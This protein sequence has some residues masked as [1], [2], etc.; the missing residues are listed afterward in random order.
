MLTDGH[1][2]GRT[3]DG[4]KVIT[5]AHPEHSSGEL[6]I[7]SFNMNTGQ[8]Y[9]D[10]DSLIE[11]VTN[12]IVSAGDMTL[13]RKTF[14]LKKNKQKKTQKLNKKCYDKD[15]DCLLRELKAAKNAFNRN[16]D[17]VYLRSIFFFFQKKIKNIKD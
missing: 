11:A 3:D 17:N 13:P 15:C 10:V 5:I 2:H 14:K 7:D 6:K 12:V 1:T 8:G 9:Y 16:T 4:R